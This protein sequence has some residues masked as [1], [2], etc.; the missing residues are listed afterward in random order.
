MNDYQSAKESKGGVFLCRLLPYLQEQTTIEDL[1]NLRRAQPRSS[2]RRRGLTE[3]RWAPDEDYK[4]PKDVNGPLLS[5]LTC[6]MALWLTA[7]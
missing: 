1:V 6:A 3:F 5:L 7:S 2:R 4:D